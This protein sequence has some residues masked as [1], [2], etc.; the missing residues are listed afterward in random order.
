MGSVFLG[1]PVFKCYGSFPLRAWNDEFFVFLLIF[2]RLKS[3]RAPS[4]AKKSVQQTRNTPFHACSENK[5]WGNKENFSYFCENNV[6]PMRV[7]RTAAML[8]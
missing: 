2:P 6:L 5:P 7:Q 3:K 8:L 1:H 4:E